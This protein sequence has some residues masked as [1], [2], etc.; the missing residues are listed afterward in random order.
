MILALIILSIILI[1]LMVLTLAMI[2]FGFYMGG[3]LEKNGYKKNLKYTIA[4]TL[5]LLSYAF[6]ICTVLILYGGGLDRL[7]IWTKGRL[8]IL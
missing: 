7:L 6:F 4:A 1:P 8:G 3:K 5:A 2:D